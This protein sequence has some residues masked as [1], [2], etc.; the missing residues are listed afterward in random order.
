[1]CEFGLMI[2]EGFVMMV[3]VEVFLWVFD[4]VIVDWLI[5]D[6]FVVVWFDDL[7]GIKFDIWLILVFFWVLGIIFCLFYLGDML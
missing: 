5:E 3:L 6:K 4:L 1:M 2:C 7:S